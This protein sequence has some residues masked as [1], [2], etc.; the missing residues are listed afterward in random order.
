LCK[1]VAI[2]QS[3]AVFAGQVMPIQDT[4]DAFR[5]AVQGHLEQDLGSKHRQM[6]EGFDLRV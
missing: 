5:S 6:L 3:Q 4:L 1:I 2:V